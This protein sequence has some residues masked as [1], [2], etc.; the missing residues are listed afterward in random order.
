[1]KSPFL[2]LSALALVATLAAG[3]TDSG[4]GSVSERPGDRTPAASPPTI[5]SPPAASP[6]TPP[7]SSTDTTTSGSGTST[8]PS[9]STSTDSTGSSSSGTK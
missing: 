1:M 7:S 2:G 3:C 4:T 5:V 9:G 6:A 8:A